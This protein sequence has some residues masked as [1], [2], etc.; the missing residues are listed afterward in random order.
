MPFGDAVVEIEG[1]PQKVAAVS[2]ILISF[3]LNALIAKTIEKLV[4]EG[5]VPPIWMSANIPGGDEF[6]KKWL[7]K[8]KNRIKLL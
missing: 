6:N 4:K 1:L 2:T 7:E 5:I 3:T 8:Y